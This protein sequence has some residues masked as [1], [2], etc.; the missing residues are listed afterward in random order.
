MG[1][2]ISVPERQVIL[3]RTGRGDPANAIAEDLGLKPDTVRRLIIRFNQ[4]G[5]AGINPDYSRCG[6][7]QTRRADADLLTTAMAMRCQ[8][9]TWGAGIIRVILAEQ[10]PGLALPTSRTIQRAF[11][12][13]GLN[14]A[15]GGRRGG[16]GGRA[17]RPHETWQIDAADQMKLAGTGQASWLRIVDECTGAVLETAVFPPRPLEYRAGGRDS[18]DAPPLL[19]TTGAATTNPGGQRNAMEVERRPAHRSGTLVGWAWRGDAGEPA[20]PPPGQRR[21]GAF[22]RHRQAVGRA[23]SGRLG[24]RA[25]GNHRRHGPSATRVLPVPRPCQSPG[26]PPRPGAFGACLRPNL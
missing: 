23:T 9:P 24:R 21:G 5:A 16:P 12:K 26:R 18:G 20:A 13:A 19:R 25:S 14:P 6:T 2:A 3:Q 15:P 22:S 7:N 8:H 1:R 10:H 4:A 11:A 17:E